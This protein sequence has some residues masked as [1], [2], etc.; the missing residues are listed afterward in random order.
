MPQKR[1]LT[2]KLGLIA[3]AICAGIGLFLGL[4]PGMDYQIRA[5]SP[6]SW[7]QTGFL[8]TARTNL[9][10]VTLLPNGQVLLVGG[11]AAQDGTGQ[12]LSNATS[13]AELYDPT[14]G[15]FNSTGTMALARAGHTA[16]LLDDGRVLFT[17][18]VDTTGTYQAT[19]ELYDPTTGVFSA[20]G[21]MTT[22]RSGHV[23]IRLSDGKVLI[24]GGFDGTDVLAIA[25][26]FD[27]I[28]EKF[29][30]TGSMQ[31]ARLNFS[32]V[33]LNDGKVL[34]LG[35]K[36]LPNSQVLFT[37]EL[38]DP[39]VGIFTSTGPLQTGRADLHQ[40]VLLES[41]DVLVAGGI[42]PQGQALA[43]AEIYSSQSGIFTLTGVMETARQ[44]HSITVLPNGQVLVT[45][46]WT[47]IGETVLTSCEIYDPSTGQFSSTGSLVAGRGYHTAMLLDNGTIL[48]AGGSGD[49]SL[50]SLALDSAEIFTCSSCLIPPDA[51]S[52]VVAIDV[53][54]DQG[55]SVHLTWIP[56]SNPD[57]T[58]YRV[59]SSTMA[60][61]SY[62][63]LTALSNPVTTTFFDDTGL[64]NGERHYYV[65]RAFD[66]NQESQNSNEVSAM[67]LDNVVPDSP[68]VVT[69]SDIASDDGTGLSLSWIPSSS[70]DIV[71]QRIHRG[72]ISGG[73][74]TQV[75]TIL[76][77]TTST[78]VDSGLTAEI[79]Y[80]YVLRAFDGTHESLMTAEVLGQPQDNRPV[81]A[82]LQYN[83][84]EDTSA[85]ITLMGQDPEGGLI[86]FLVATPPAHGQLTGSLPQLTY[87]PVADFNGVDSFQYVVSAGSLTSE[88][89]IVVLTVSSLNDPP[90]AVA[91]AL[92]A[93]EDVSGMV[94]DVL[95]NDTLGPDEGEVLR[96]ASVT[97]STQGGSVIVASDKQNI[98]YT[99]PINFSGT[100]T[101]TYTM[102]DGSPNSEATAAVTV[103]VMPVN[104]PPSISPLTFSWTPSPSTNVV[105]L[106]VYRSTNS[107]GPYQLM[108]SFNNPLETRFTDSNGLD[109][110]TTYYYV[111]RAFDGTQ[112]SVDSNEIH[113][114]S[115]RPSMVGEEDTPVNVTLAGYDL[116]SPSITYVIEQGPQQGTLTGSGPQ[117]VYTPFPDFVGNDSFTYTVTDGALSSEIGIAT[118]S[119][120]GVNDAP[121]ATS[122][123]LQVDTNTETA[124]VLTGEDGDPELT[125]GLSYTIETLPAVGSVS[126]TAGGPALMG[127]QLPVSLSTPTLYYQAS[128]V[129]AGPVTLTFHIQDDGGTANGGI[130]TSSSAS[131]S[132][133][134]LPHS[135]TALTVTDI[136]LDDGTALRVS[137]TPSANGGIVEQRLYRGLTG[138]GPYALVA[139]LS[140]NTATNIVDTGL[141]AATDYYYVLSAFDGTQE[142]LFT[143]EVSGQPQDNRPVATALQLELDED[144]LVALTLVGEDPKGGSVTYT[145]TTPPTN[146]QLAGIP[147]QLTYTPDQDFNGADSFTYVVST[148]TLTSEPAT[149][150]VTV[151]PVN[152]LP[153]A[154][155]DEVTMGEDAAAV[156]LDVLGNDSSGPDS[157]DV[158]TIISV[159]T[160]SQ[161][162]SVIVAPDTQ[163]LQYTPPVNFSG[164]DTFSYTI[165]DGTLNSEATATVT[166]T[167]TPVNDTPMAIGQTLQVNSNTEIL[168]TLT[169]EDGDSE[170]TQGLSYTVDT[171]PAVGVISLTAGGPA[172]IPAQLP[173]SLVTPKLYYR[174]PSEGTGPV[175][176]TFHVQDDGGTAN[177]GVNIS[178][179]AIVI[180]NILP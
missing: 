106:R 72:L 170:V 179:P 172:I 174:A 10:T 52:Q 131:V 28:T 65:V 134:V 164:T 82:A 98:L 101:F 5:D 90:V 141:I 19:S 81:A 47:G 18:G 87:V 168:L 75:G 140:G 3:F 146:G 33:L 111:V 132:L 8:G 70:D 171:V 2:T 107:G 133:T 123:T 45:G 15:A 152:D 80:Y 73:P 49:A 78:F 143:A 126:L 16:T 169:G 36:S 129:G 74:Y 61:G 64:A 144:A 7:T 161:G 63:L 4:M 92:A 40:T 138:G 58:E 69:V 95:A 79:S 55:G 150:D 57:V 175:A 20:M 116:D 9:A 156:Q 1:K 147:P 119:I 109:V 118:V 53:P 76:G 17:G 71:E 11:Q 94:L 167:V 97:T 130:D 60:G 108:G 125:Q 22:A 178:S 38:Y 105:E 158:L 21:S 102:T 14:T 54:S 149:V 85:S 34:V 23:A 6:G 120:S 137:W 124:I 153:V 26:V 104:D 50:S 157:G 77:N 68:S 29:S 148:E 59:Y 83:F 121:V 128:S 177:G 155:A 24:V 86:N 27:P 35:G 31:D 88:P 115:G 44:Y 139:T 12:G 66:G 117:M 84:E 114:V 154:V 113:S 112:E 100:D 42:G 162:G 122:Q 160:P 41:G 180:V 25:E 165:T 91:D 89:A 136:P 145:V 43:S 99:P 56:S 159:S 103:T 37:A 32:A 30:S 13:V 166:V 62:S 173:L 46:G 151:T 51:P 127:A 48:V 110:G 135:P 176:L 93:L 67:S 39:V 163:S 96:I 142:S